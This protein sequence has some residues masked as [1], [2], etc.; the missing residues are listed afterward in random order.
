[1]R[2]MQLRPL[3][4]ELVF[5]MAGLVPAIH[6]FLRTKMWMPGTRPGMTAERS[7]QDTRGAVVGA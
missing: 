5:V 1:M 3:G 4:M 7:V 6:A 2:L